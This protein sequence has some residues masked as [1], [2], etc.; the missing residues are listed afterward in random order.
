VFALAGSD[1]V[2]A[3]IVLNA[4]FGVLAAVAAAGLAR[5]LWGDLAGAIAGALLALSAPQVA[6]EALLLGDAVLPALVLAALWAAVAALDGP[7]RGNWRW[8]AGGALLGLLI[9][10][11]GSN[12]LPALAMVAGVSA[13]LLRTGDGSRWK[14]L[15][16][17]AILAA[18]MLAP[19]A[20]VAVRNRVVGE[21]WALTDNGPVNLYLGNAPGA[22]GTFSLPPGYEAADAEIRRLPRAERPAAWTARLAA[23]WAAH[24]GDDSRVRAILRKAGIFANSWLAADNAN[25]YFLREY[26]PALQW[27]AGAW[28]LHALGIAGVWHAWRSG[29]RARLLLLFAAAFALSI[30]IVF[31][32]GRYKLPWLALAAVLGGG[33]IARAIGDARARRWN[34]VIAAAA[35]FA[36]AASLTRPAVAERDRVAYSGLLRPNEFAQNIQALVRAGRLEEAD[37]LLARAAEAFPQILRFREQRVALA[38]QQGK[39]EAALALTAPSLHSG[40]VTEIEAEGHVIA[41]AGLGRDQEASLIAIQLLRHFPESDLLRRA[42]APHKR[43]P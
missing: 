13:L 18:A 12:A 33:A 7:G 17:A 3:G 14:R 28:P 23:D 10:G 19:V 32:A 20:A 40:Y 21:R 25:Y 8:I 9:V 1:S 30:V 24:R 26:V 15:V 42:A 41:L 34:P 27:L 35:L 22:S 36:A 2:A 43:G 38:I 6:H 11:R 29:P 37:V 16:P 5:V 4:A 39:W 31:V